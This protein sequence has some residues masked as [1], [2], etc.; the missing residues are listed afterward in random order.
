MF[1]LMLLGILF[2]VTFFNFT[3]SIRYYNHD[4]FMIDTFE[5]ND[6]TVSAEAVTQ[7]PNHGELCYTISMRGFYLSVPLALWLFGPIWMLTDSLVL[8][9]VLHRLDRE[10]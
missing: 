6:F 10:T 4:G 1:K 3:L 7:V 8:M 9:A 2:F 5:Q